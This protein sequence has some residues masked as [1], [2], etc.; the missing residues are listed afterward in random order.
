V[1]AARVYRLPVRHAVE[2]L[3][4][5]R[6]STALPS[7]LIVVVL[8]VLV[9]AVYL[10][11][12][13]ADQY[14]AEFRL[15]LRSGDAPAA[16]PLSLFG[17]ELSRSPAAAESQVVAQ[18]IASR[19]IVD[20]LDPKLDLRRL[21][22]PPYADGWAALPLPASIEELVHYWKGQVDPFY[23]A[24]TGTIVVRV[25][26][27]DAE[28]ALRLASAIVAASEQL[29]ND[30][31]ARARR[32]AVRTAEDEVAQA[33]TRLKA[34][35][36]RIREFRD[37]EGIL[38]PGKTAEATAA[39]ATSLRGDLLK[40]SS[41]LATLK[42]YMTDDAPPVK[43]LRA[44]IRSL[45]AQQRTLGN[46]MTAGPTGH[47][48]TLS[49]SLGSYEQLEA[50]RKFAD[51]AYQHALESLDRARDNADR[52]HI[53]IASFVPPS[54]PESALYPRRWRSLGV[55]MLIAFA[56]WA[57]GALAVQSVRDHL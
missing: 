24:A 10:F 22:S 55:V 14:V 48:K 6:W 27:F 33:E 35:L 9:A 7:F 42:A 11:L 1:P 56:V 47:A 31:S 25:R 44:R 3:H 20:A 12:I 28:G 32:D 37:R 4:R 41:D 38:D 16:D 5:R 40:A 13:A 30:L 19:A 21:F 43:V 18:Y 54:L 39:L 2:P 34:A 52:Q 15:T 57:I 36:A 53:Y 46:E 50:D 8:P 23:D 29:V 49:Q 45:E 26:A 17:S 51:T